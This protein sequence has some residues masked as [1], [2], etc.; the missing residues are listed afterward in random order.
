[1]KLIR[2]IAAAALAT[3]LTMGVAVAGPNHGP[4]YGA[5]G[6]TRN[7]PDGPA[8][9]HRRAPNPRHDLRC[10]RGL[11]GETRCNHSI[12]GRYY[13]PETYE[14]ATGTGQHIQR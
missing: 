2:M 4:Q 3:G 5:Y 8:K 7:G 1:M 12:N 10:E 6:V 13:G 14:Y 9:H 11:Y